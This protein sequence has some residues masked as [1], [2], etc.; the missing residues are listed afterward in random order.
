[1]H[2]NSKRYSCISMPS[3]TPNANW[4]SSYSGNS[5]SSPPKF[6]NAIC[7]SSRFYLSAPPCSYCASPNGRVSLP[8]FAMP[9]RQSFSPLP[10]SCSISHAVSSI[11]PWPFP[12][13]LHRVSLTLKQSLEM[14][15]E[16]SVLGLVAHEC[17]GVNFYHNLLK[18]FTGFIKA[19]YLKNISIFLSQLD[20]IGLQRTLEWQ[21]H[22]LSSIGLEKFTVELHPLQS[23]SMEEALHG[24]HGHDDSHRDV[25]EE[26]HSQSDDDRVC[27]LYTASD[28]FLQEDSGELTV[29]QG[30]GPKTKV[31]CCVRD[32]SED[33]FNCFDYLM[34]SDFRDIVFFMSVAFLCSDFLL[35]FFGTVE[36]IRHLFDEAVFNIS[37]LF[38][39]RSTGHSRPYDERLEDEHP[40]HANQWHHQQ[41]VLQGLLRLHIPQ[42]LALSRTH[43]QRQSDHLGNQRRS[44]RGLSLLSPGNS[45][46][47]NDQHA[48]VPKGAKEENL[49]G[50]PLEEEIDIIFEMKSIERFQKDGYVGKEVPR[51]IWATPI[52]TANFILYELK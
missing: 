38:V 50:Q 20:R 16:E 52:I 48:H 29:G 45:P 12:P 14:V 2:R 22:E 40:R 24:V 27:W 41:V 49:L 18:F 23:E 7:T 17:F 6:S 44:L 47:V 35:S 15:L 36:V 46:F 9:N 5:S 42:R 13:L 28:C 30:Q 31:W 39:V 10:I 32:T 43:L 11:A 34:H 25:E 26:V 1:M 51:V 4:P 33:K 37:V 19:I 3:S 8:L 21:R